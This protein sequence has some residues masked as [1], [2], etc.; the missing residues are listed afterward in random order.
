MRTLYLT[1]CC[2]CYNHKEHIILYLKTLVLVRPD[3]VCKKFY[4]KKKYFVT[5]NLNTNYDAVNKMKRVKK[6]YIGCIEATTL[7]YETF[8]LNK[9]DSILFLKS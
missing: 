8:F 6:I 5:L 9:C 2:Q 7:I 1:Y 4:I 3:I